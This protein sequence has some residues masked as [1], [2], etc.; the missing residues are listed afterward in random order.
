MKEQ[1]FNHHE[2]RRSF[3]EYLRAFSGRAFGPGCDATSHHTRPGS[4]PLA[5]SHSDVLQ[6]AFTGP[7]A[8]GLS[9]IA[10][11]VG[12]LMFAFGEGG[13]KK[14]LAGII[15][16][17]GN[18]YGRGQL[19]SVALSDG[20]R[21][22]MARI[23]GAFQTA[24]HHGRRAPLV[25]VERHVGACLVERHQLHCGRRIDLCRALTASGFGPGSKTPT[26]LKS[27]GRPRSFAPATIPANGRRLPG[28]FSF[29]DSE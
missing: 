9:L 11:V 12:G 7:I 23:P 8:R 27:C 21:E 15:F 5:A 6:D 14:A 18:G 10:V 28:R 25:S 1:T 2:T 17:L 19:S 24:H 16:G 3:G 22:N 13:S 26:C 29:G 4:K 20:T